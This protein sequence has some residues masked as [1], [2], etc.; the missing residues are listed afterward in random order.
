M[1]EAVKIESTWWALVEIPQQNRAENF[2]SY[3]LR[4]CNTIDS[5]RIPLTSEANSFRESER[6][7]DSRVE[8]VNGK[9]ILKFHNF[10]WENWQKKIAGLEKMVL[11]PS[12][13]ENRNGQRF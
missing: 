5:V 3:V 4:V 10:M 9:K 7:K 11:I 13:S 6:D 8:R 1:Q 2:A 12:D